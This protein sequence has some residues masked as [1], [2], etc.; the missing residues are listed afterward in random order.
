MDQKKKKGI[1][2]VADLQARLAA[3]GV[4]RGIHEQ[5]LKNKAKQVEE[6]AELL[7]SPKKKLAECASP[8]KSK[9]ARALFSPKKSVPDYVVP[10]F[11]IHKSAE[12][13]RDEQDDAHEEEGKRMTTE[14]LKVSRLTEEVKDSV[15]N[16]IQLPNS[17]EHLAD[18]FKR[19]DQVY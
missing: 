5:N 3:K 4:A 10:G 19:V 9:V 8:T 13:V 14:F 15:R 11:N 1:H 17:Y 2:T 12:K 6:H 18:S 16:R 7:K